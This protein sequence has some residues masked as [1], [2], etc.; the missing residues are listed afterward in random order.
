M[1]KLKTTI[2]T[3]A[4]AAVIAAIPGAASA[5]APTF[6]ELGRV[7]SADRLGLT[8][9][10]PG[11]KKLRSLRHQL[12][13]A[14]FLRR[15]VPAKA[16]PESKARVIKG[17]LYS[18]NAWPGSRTE[19]G[20][21]SVAAT[22]GELILLTSEEMFSKLDYVANGGGTPFGKNYYY[23]TSYASRGYGDDF[24]V[25]AVMNTVFDAT[26]WEPVQARLQTDD[27]NN[28]VLTSIATAM[29]SDP[30]TGQIYGTF[31][32]EDE[33][34]YSFG[35]YS[36]DGFRLQVIRLIDEPWEACGF[37]TDGTLYAMTAD[38]G[39][40]K[41]DKHSGEMTLI[42]N[43]GLVST[44]M[45]SGAVNPDDHKFYFNVVGDGGSEMWKIDL[46][47]GEAEKA[48][49][50][51][52]GEEL[53]GLYFSE[54]AAATLAPAAVS[55]LTA[56]FA[57]TLSADVS[58]T[59][60]TLSVGGDA[61][62]GEV[63]WT[64]S[65]GYSVH[66]SG[67][68]Q[69]GAEVTVPVTVENE[70]PVMIDV[71][72][73]NEMGSGPTASVDAYAGET[74]ALPESATNL[75]VKEDKNHWGRLT[76]SWK[77][78]ARDVNGKAI[79]PE[80]LVYW[81]S[82]HNLYSH[83]RDFSGTSIVMDL[84]DL[85]QKQRF[86]KFML[87]T[88]CDLGRGVSY[89]W[90]SFL[91][92]DLISYGKPY[93]LPFYD[94]IGPDGFYYNWI[95][96]SSPTQGHWTYWDGI[97]SSWVNIEP[98]GR[99]GGMVVFQPDKDNAVSEIRGGKIDL[100]TAKHPTLFFHAYC[101]PDWNDLIS[102][103]VFEADCQDSEDVTIFRNN[104]DEEGWVEFSL[105]LDD[106]AGHTI[107]LAF[108]AAMQKKTSSVIA[109]DEIEVRNCL[110]NDLGIRGFSTPATLTPGRAA[111]FGATVRNWGRTDV[112][113]WSA[114]LFCNGRA[115]AAQNFASLAAGESCPVV[116]DIVPTPLFDEICEFHIAISHEGDSDPDN[117]STPV[118]TISFV[119]SAYPA[120]QSLD[121]RELA[122]GSAMLTWL[123]PDLTGADGLSLEGFNLYRDA[124]KVNDQPITEMDYN[125]AAVSG[126]AH[127]YHVTAVYTEGESAP[128]EPFRFVA[129]AVDAIGADAF[130]AVADGRTVTVTG[131]ADSVAV[132]DIAGRLVA[133]EAPAAV[134]TF[135]LPAGVYLVKAGEAVAKVAVN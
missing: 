93:E 106:F 27:H 30:A 33:E 83:C 132:Y 105:P 39:F 80:G 17:S 63:T 35:I 126:G 57:G 15:A 42:R 46:T 115:L 135:A 117:N 70:G 45:T 23:M 104:A 59:L 79:T 62:E 75:V 7:H 109:I 67:K 31:F 48:F 129:T 78:P 107:Q 112:G 103:V 61:L 28:P 9:V 110:D 74:K 55:G 43:T 85:S 127:V 12:P 38:G 34:Q 121:G 44:Y 3:L 114:T 128:S 2:A 19:W 88:G 84:G 20:I 134:H 56:K 118:E 66:S 22:G 96:V 68:G 21:Y 24:E 1:K 11:A 100:G 72:C 82:N 111:G 13:E 40:H 50:F 130:A 116:F 73:S 47:T 101:R 102:V 52:H 71:Y 10:K 76:A 51:N 131:T 87:L 8:A 37:D 65:V 99:D 6:R 98:Y 16:A 108:V 119:Q 14:S 69:P 54:P 89:N 26:T 60:P 29:S 18:S 92:S 49:N 5:T 124:A 64:M 91:S 36:T 25:T 90:D 97:S 58:F 41:V 133:R 94:G 125:D 122:D 120:P 81:L 113:A 123:E 32:G 4:A 53:L 86:D 95:M 77:A